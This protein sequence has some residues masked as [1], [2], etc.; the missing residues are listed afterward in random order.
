MSEP[1]SCD[2]QCEA[3]FGSFMSR[4]TYTQ[5]G[6]LGLPQLQARDRLERY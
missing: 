1:L 5:A 6:L 2:L 3:F 4:P